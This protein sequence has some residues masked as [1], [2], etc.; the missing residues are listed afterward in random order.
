MPK[1][2]TTNNFT[3]TD[4]GRVIYGEGKYAVENR[5]KVM[6][7]VGIKYSQKKSVC[8]YCTRI[9]YFDNFHYFVYNGQPAAHDHPWFPDLNMPEPES[10]AGHCPALHNRTPEKDMKYRRLRKL[11]GF[12]EALPEERSDWK[13]V[14]NK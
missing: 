9:D 13:V 5:Q 8:R 14:A 2:K 10:H 7:K 11:K 3:I 6:E 1:K 4:D 12:S